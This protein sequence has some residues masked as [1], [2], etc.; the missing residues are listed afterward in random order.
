MALEA[1]GS[2][3]FTHPIP[4]GRSIVPAVLFGMSPSGKAQD[5]DSCSRGFESRHP[6]H[7]N[8]SFVQETK[9]GFFNE[10]AP[11]ELMKQ[12][13]DAALMKK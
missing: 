1:D 5:F 9:E 8:S 12:N 4:P 3:P 7:K 11:W 10:V 13:E 6:S 2:T